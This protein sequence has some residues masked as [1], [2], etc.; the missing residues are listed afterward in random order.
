MSQQRQIRR[1]MNGRPRH[2]R[3]VDE[4]DP[5]RLAARIGVTTF[6]ARILLH[7]TTISPAGFLRGLGIRRVDGGA[8]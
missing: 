3:T 5:R 4:V 8:L 6:E 1:N 7:G 2:A